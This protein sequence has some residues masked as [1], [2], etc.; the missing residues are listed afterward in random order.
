MYDNRTIFSLKHKIL[1]SMM[2]KR[3]K[4]RYIFRYCGKGKTKAS[5]CV[6]RVKKVV[7][8]VYSVLLCYVYCVIH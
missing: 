8:K 6:G 2:Q 3:D 7:R 4:K 1:K 5:T